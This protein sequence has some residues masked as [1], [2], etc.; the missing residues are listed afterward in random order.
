[1]EEEEGFC[2]SI[3][4]CLL[5]RFFFLCSGI[6]FARPLIFIKKNRQKERDRDRFH[7]VIRPSRLALLS[8]ARASEEEVEDVVVVVVA[9]SRRQ[10]E[11]R[12]I[13]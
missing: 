3:F 5:F 1:L 9:R 12:C 8:T 6:V 13:E 7:F 11:K 2:V 10:K 4:C